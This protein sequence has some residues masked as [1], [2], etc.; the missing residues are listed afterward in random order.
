MRTRSRIRTG[1]SYLRGFTLIELLV[2]IAI[3]A[4]LVALLL[5]AVQQAR[6]AARRS[7][8]KNNLK[9]IGVALHNYHDTHGK[10]PLNRIGGRNGINQGNYGW[11]SQLLPQME[12]KNLYD[13]LD[14]NDLNQTGGH[15]N[16]SALMQTII[17][18]LLCPSNP[19]QALATN[20]GGEANGWRNGLSGGRTDYVGNMGWQH[21]GHRDCPQAPRAGNWNGA[22][23]ADV[24]SGGPLAGCNGVIGWRGCI[25]LRDI[26]DGTSNT[27]AV[28][29]NHHWVEKE[30][31]AQI[32]GDAMWF[33]PWAIHSV[34]MPINH[35]PNTDFRCDQWSS[36]HTG[37]AQGLLADG[38]VKFFSEN[39]GWQI[40]RGL[41][42]RAGGEV[43]GEF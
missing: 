29:E 13:Q 42:T 21:A 32:Q 3:I 34:K 22:A 20:Q 6:E 18:G 38:A 31:A 19:Q 27:L 9:Q 37:G 40:Q 10:L 1:R 24:N 35:D 2:V 12:E 11:L 23:W 14:W 43:I 4:I 16:N 26:T 28:M 36:T 8:C 15:A 41:G 30:D 17:E 33:G 5:P 39:L 7:S 25:G